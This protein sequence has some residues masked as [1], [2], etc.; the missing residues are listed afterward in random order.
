MKKGTGGG[1][2]KRKWGED[3]NTNRGRGGRD[4]RGGR[5]GGRGNKPER[6]GNIFTCLFKIRT[7]F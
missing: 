4:G 3:N 5:G 6:E 2:G 7:T 1:E